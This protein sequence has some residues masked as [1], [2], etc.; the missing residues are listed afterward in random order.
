MGSTWLSKASNFQLSGNL[1]N[2]HA[3]ETY[4]ESWYVAESKHHFQMMHMNAHQ[5]G[6]KV[7]RCFYHIKEW[8]FAA[9]IIDARL[10]NNPDWDWRADDIIAVVMAMNTVFQVLRGYV[11]SSRNLLT[12][13]SS[14]D[15][16][17]TKR[18][19]GSSAHANPS[20]RQRLRVA[21]VE[22]NRENKTT[23]CAGG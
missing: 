2:I 7:L 18:L 10:C 5:N 11:C 8:I 22:E 15:E 19:L 16:H 6:E 9:I 14:G 3:T 17:M 23:A 20:T 12:E 1:C 21:K 13:P 4:T